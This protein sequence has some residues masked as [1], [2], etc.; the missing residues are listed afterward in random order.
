MIKIG[1]GLRGLR[2]TINSQSEVGY[3]SIQLNSQDFKNMRA[4]SMGPT[5][6][7]GSCDRLGRDHPL[8]WKCDKSLEILC[9]L[10][11]SIVA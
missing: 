1:G 2:R 4:Q 8:Y 11:S 9:K 6:F 7:L 5:R 10:F 3:R